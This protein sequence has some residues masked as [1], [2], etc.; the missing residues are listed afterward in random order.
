MF[1]LTAEERARARKKI[2]DNFVNY[3]ENHGVQE[4]EE[5]RSYEL[6]IIYALNEMKKIKGTTEEEV[7]NSKF[8]VSQTKRFALL[9]SAVRKETAPEGVKQKQHDYVATHPELVARNTEAA[10]VVKDFFNKKKPSNEKA[11]SYQNFTIAVV[12]GT[13]EHEQCVFIKKE[14]RGRLVFFQARVY[15]S[16]RGHAILLTPTLR[17]LEQFQLAPGNFEKLFYNQAAHH[18]YNTVA[19]QRCAHYTW[20][21]VF[22]IF[23]WDKRNPFERNVDLLARELGTID[24]GN[25]MA[26][27][28][29]EKR[30]KEMKRNRNVPHNQMEH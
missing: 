9:A 22:V 29:D 7:R 17:F 14:Y 12:C 4:H 8:V 13:T 10:R 20:L 21:E 15:D 26:S 18:Q 19:K 23:L 1:S 3:F 11:G 2:I 6:A 16:N 24:H 30:L 27:P 25:R 28:K 5:G